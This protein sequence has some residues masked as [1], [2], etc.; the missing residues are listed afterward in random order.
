MSGG[1]RRRDGL[2]SLSLTSPLKCVKITLMRL[3]DVDFKGETATSKQ[4][5]KFAFFLIWCYSSFLILAES[6]ILRLVP[7]TGISSF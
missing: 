4:V 3:A 1:E 6:F 5:F 2:P 7:S